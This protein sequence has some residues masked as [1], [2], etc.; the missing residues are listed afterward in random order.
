[1]DNRFCPGA[2][3][4]KGTPTLDV[5]TCPECGEAVEI[6]STDKECPCPRCGFTIFSDLVSCLRW[7]KYAQKCL[8]GEDRP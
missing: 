6:F 2:A 5:K 8:G 3:N 7:C 1:M 4:I